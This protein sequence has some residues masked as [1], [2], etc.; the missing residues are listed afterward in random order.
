M[1]KEDQDVAP[2]C[3]RCEKSNKQTSFEEN[4]G[5]SVFMHH[6]L[7]LSELFVSLSWF[8]SFKSAKIDGLG[9]VTNGEKKLEEKGKN[10]KRDI[11]G[12]REY[13]NHSSFIRSCVVFFY[14]YVLLYF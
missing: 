5:L 8:K 9:M 14:V 12:L 7:P 10:S 2:L 11:N 1:F 4:Y 3:G 6:T 13:V